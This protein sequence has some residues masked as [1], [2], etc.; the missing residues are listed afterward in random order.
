[1]VVGNYLCSY[2][3]D[4]DVQVRM[5]GHFLLFLQSV[6]K[7]LEQCTMSYYPSTGVLV[8]RPAP[9]LEHNKE[10]LHHHYSHTTK[11]DNYH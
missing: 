5:E 1:M 4:I 3:F 6:A 7:I 2:T 9:C 8:S 10:S 11:F